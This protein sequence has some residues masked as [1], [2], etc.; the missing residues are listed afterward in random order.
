MNQLTVAIRNN[1]VLSWC[2]ALCIGFVYRYL[3]G[4][5]KDGI[6]LHRNLDIINRMTADYSQGKLIVFTAFFNIFVELSS[7]IIPAVICALFLTHVFQKKAI[8][9][10]SGAILTFLLLSSRLWRYWC[11]PTLPTNMKII[12]FANPIVDVLVLIF[13]IWLILKIKSYITAKKKIHNGADLDI[14]HE[15]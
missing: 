9:F 4:R 11:N 14:G 8:F 12:G 3:Y 7:S 5:M 15:K 13:T 1:K 10:S 2:F 6:W